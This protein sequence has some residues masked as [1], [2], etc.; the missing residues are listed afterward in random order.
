[1]I[2]G[3]GVGVVPA[4]QASTPAL[5]AGVERNSRRSSGDYRRT[6]GSLVVA[7]VALVLLVS[8]GLLFRSLS[9]LLAVDTGFDDAPLLTMQVQVTGHRYDADSV[10]YG[11]LEQ[12]LEAVRRV[13][14]VQ[15]AAYTSQL[16][17]SDDLDIY[18][19]HLER[20]TDPAND[21]AALRYAVTS[22][23]FAAMGIPLRGGR[24]LDEHDGASSPR[25][26]VVSEAF[27]RS[28]FSGADPIGQ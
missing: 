25:A 3:I 2:I 20:E 1:A 15:A 21:G 14:G 16:P 4:L 28:A 24:L 12:S 26:V 8:A 7:E 23:Y 19:V 17:L 22:G 10:R 13:P 6:R 5:R 27:A 9:R 18:G 11:F